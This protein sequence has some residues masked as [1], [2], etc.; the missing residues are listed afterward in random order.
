MKTLFILL[1][2]SI[3]LLASTKS[4]YQ[5]WQP[6]SLKGTDVYGVVGVESNQPGVV[7][8]PRPVVL[9]GAIPEDLVTAIAL[10]Y[11]L[12]SSAKNYSEPHVNLLAI[13]NVS[14]RALLEDEGLLIQFD[15]SKAQSEKDLGVDLETVISMGIEA[16]RKTAVFNAKTQL[17]NPLR[18]I[19]KVVG[20]EKGSSLLKL[21][22]QFDIGP[23]T[24]E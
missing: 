3:S 11:P 22:T 18:C 23:G 8:M 15:V 12:A 17:D 6:L 20:A 5:I 13:S 7:I 14:L 19:V 16:V 24:G 1:S 2:L 9:S 21:E 10:D 4:V